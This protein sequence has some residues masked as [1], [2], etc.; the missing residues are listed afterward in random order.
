MNEQEIEQTNPL[1]SVVISTCNEEKLLGTCLESLKSQHCDFYYEIIVVDAGSSDGT[2]AIAR[3]YGAKVIQELRP[4]AVQARSAGFANARGSIIDSTDADT[5][6]PSD[7]L[8][9]I[10]KIFIDNPKVPDMVAF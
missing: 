6:L 4:G 9:R 2:T 3:Q 10:R 5:A 1:I 8:A 7:W